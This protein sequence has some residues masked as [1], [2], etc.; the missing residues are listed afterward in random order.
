MSIGLGVLSHIPASLTVAC[1]LFV[2]SPPT[3]GWHPHFGEENYVF[4]QNTR[5]LYQ[6][7][8][9]LAYCGVFS[10]GIDSDR[11]WAAWTP[12][13]RGW[14]TSTDP[15]EP[16]KV[17]YPEEGIT[18]IGERTAPTA[19]VVYIEEGATSDRQADANFEQLRRFGIFHQNAATMPPEYAPP[20]GPVAEL[21]ERKPPPLPR[22]R[23]APSERVLVSALVDAEE[24]EALRAASGVRA[25]G[26]ARAEE[27]PQRP[28]EMF[29]SLFG[30][31]PRC[32][33]FP[34]R[35][36]Y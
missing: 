5:Q 35:D 36:W 2:A 3:V 11:V 20:T 13:E 30:D 1:Q 17:D 24:R 28:F 8:N 14:G 16:A 10:N 22:P 15:A 25:V 18:P 27:C 34:R 21:P 4:G 29:F 7:A 12:P 19:Q 32:P 31:A 9:D 23:P 26:T 6:Q 33:M